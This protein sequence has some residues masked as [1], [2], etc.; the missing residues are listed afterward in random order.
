M[1]DTSSLWSCL[2]LIFRRPLLM[3]C[4]LCGSYFPCAELP[5]CLERTVGVAGQRWHLHLACRQEP[6]ERREAARAR[7]ENS[8]RPC[9]E[10]TRRK[11]LTRVSC[12]R[13][14]LLN[15]RVVQ[16][17]EN[18]QRLP[19]RGRRG[20][21]AGFHRGEGVAVPG[22]L[23]LVRGRLRRRSQVRRVASPSVCSKSVRFLEHEYE[24]YLSVTFIFC[25][26]LTENTPT[27]STLG[28]QKHFVFAV[29]HQVRK[30]ETLFAG[31]TCNEYLQDVPLIG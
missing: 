29:S 9:S 26:P 23:R 4:C 14:A 18:E 16:G 24:R 30:I 5:P 13:L 3:R 31:R 8:N 27:Q 7:V 25:P 11:V 17:D 6:G 1:P 20:R 12:L 28:A 22:V 19:G 10:A 15:R 21:R 2:E